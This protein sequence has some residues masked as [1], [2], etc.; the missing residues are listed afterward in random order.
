MLIGKCDARIFKCLKPAGP[1]HELEI[2]TLKPRL[3]KRS[4]SSRA[5]GARAHIRGASTILMRA[6]LPALRRVDDPRPYKLNGKGI[7]LGTEA[8]FRHAANINARRFVGAG[9]EVCWRSERPSLFV[10]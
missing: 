10:A 8:G 9:A 1:N 6:Q 3:S 4:F 7:S 2:Q 5:T